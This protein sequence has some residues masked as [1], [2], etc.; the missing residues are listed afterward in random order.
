MII[1]IRLQIALVLLIH[2]LKNMHTQNFGNSSLHQACMKGYTDIT[3]LLIESGAML[4]I[5]DN[6]SVEVLVAC[7]GM[8]S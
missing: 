7:M 8:G 6:V 2:L 5:K 1:K 4:E 3:K